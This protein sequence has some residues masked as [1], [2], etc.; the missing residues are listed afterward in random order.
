MFVQNGK[1]TQNMEALKVH[2]RDFP[3]KSNLES[4]PVKN[5][6]PAL[7]SRYT[8]VA[9]RNKSHL[10]VLGRNCGMDDLTGD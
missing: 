6:T 2:G 8:I 4:L 1:Q 5:E 7:K 10:S 9:Q 3:Y